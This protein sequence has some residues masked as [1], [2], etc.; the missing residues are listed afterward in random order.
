MRNKNSYRMNKMKWIMI[1]DRH[2]II[3][4]I[5]LKVNKVLRVEVRKV[6]GHKVLKDTNLNF[7]RI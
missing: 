4:E 6:I 7:N 1:I 5:H 2:Q 3:I